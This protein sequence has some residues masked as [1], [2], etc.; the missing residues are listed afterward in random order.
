MRRVLF[1]SK[2]IVPPWHDGSKN[3]VRDVA[4]SLTAWAPTVL[5]TPESPEVDGAT[6]WPVYATSGR[7]SPSLEANAR[8]LAALVRAHGFDAWHFAFAPNLASSSAA[9]VAIAAGKRRGVR[10]VVQT[11]AS[12]PKRFEG[13]RALLF[14]DVVVAL[15]EWTRAR[16]LAHGAVGQRMIVIPPCA[17]APRAV[18]AEEIATV[19][20]AFDLG[21]GPI[22]LYPGDLEISSGARTMLRA[23]PDLARRVPEARVVFAC[24]RKT[25]AAFDAE[26]RLSAEAEALGVSAQCRFVGELP[27]LA[28][29]LAAAASVALP[30]DDLYGKVDVPLVVIE[31]LAAGVPLVLARGGPLETVTSAAFVEPGESSALA[32]AV[33]A[34]IRRDGPV[35]ES[36]EAGRALYRATFAPSAVAARYEAAYD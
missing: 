17:R 6:G 33:V 7:F 10:R 16:M 1:V 36:V 22:V 21:P 15:S 24:R 31:A 32:D 13:V 5:T 35:R 2:P 20:R 30:A 8:V 26:A 18:S 23:V 12:R 29:L 19:R 14:G 28:P 27:E 11:V 3:L 25:A 9:R 4:T 34:Q